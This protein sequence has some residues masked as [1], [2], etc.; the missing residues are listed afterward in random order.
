VERTIPVP[1]T[2]AFLKQATATAA[3]L[4]AARLAPAIATRDS[5]GGTE[6]VPLLIET[7]RDQLLEALVARIR[8]GLDYPTLLGAIAEASVRQVRPYPHVEFKYHAF[9]VPKAVHRTRTLGRPEDRW[10]AVLWAA[11]IFEGFQAAEQRSGC[12]SIGPVREQLVPPAHKAESAFRDAMES[13]GSGGGRRIRDRP[14]ALAAAGPALRPQEGH[15]HETA[16]SGRHAHTT[17]YAS[18]SGSRTGL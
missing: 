12:W 18:G 2:R 6:L 14:G 13:L 17:R 5:L 11:D 4:G 16:T 9:M 3:A 15:L 8:G 1:D 10:L 7:D